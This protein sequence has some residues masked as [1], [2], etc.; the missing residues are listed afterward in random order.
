MRSLPYH[1]KSLLFFA[2]EGPMIHYEK[3]ILYI[4][5]LNPEIKTQWR[6]SRKE[7]VVFGWNCILSAFKP[8]AGT[9][10]ATEA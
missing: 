6:M 5:D 4:Q 3:G 10:S 2:H 8:P 1:E 7:M 9:P